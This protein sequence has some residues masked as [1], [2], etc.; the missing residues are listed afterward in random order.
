MSILVVVIVS[1][2]SNQRT[3]VILVLVLSIM[4][5]RYAYK[6]IW[7]VIIS[8][9]SLDR[10]SHDA[11]SAFTAEVTNDLS[12]ENCWYYQHVSVVIHT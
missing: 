9:H 10:S 3:T 8:G 2:K 4:E 11:N 12:N 5:L 1:D 7:E 6:G